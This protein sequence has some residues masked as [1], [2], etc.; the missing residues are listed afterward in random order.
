MKV[1]LG[2]GKNKKEGFVGVDI[3]PRESVDLVADLRRGLPFAESSVTELRAI[4]LFEHISDTAGLM[5][6]VYRACAPG[7][8]VTIEVPYARS[9]GAFADPT[10]VSLFTEGTWEYF[11]RGRKAWEFYQFDFDFKIKSLR[12]NYLKGKTLKRIPLVGKLLRWL[13]RKLL[14]R[15]LWNVVF[16]VTV[17]LEVVKPARQPEEEAR[18]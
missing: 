4:H 5:G 11:D 17:E 7:A 6:E 15:A 10:H 1:E 2:C 16:S 3:A 12:F 8:L 14:W 13:V 18:R 9:D